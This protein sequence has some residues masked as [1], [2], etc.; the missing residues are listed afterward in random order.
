MVERET[1]T[2]SLKG[3]TDSREEKDFLTDVRKGKKDDREDRKCGL[4]IA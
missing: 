2:S 1:I 3:G 4:K